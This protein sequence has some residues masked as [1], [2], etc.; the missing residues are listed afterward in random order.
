MSDTSKAIVLINIGTPDEP[1]IP[2]VYRYLTQFLNDKRVIDLPY[3]LRKFLVNAIIIPFRVKNSTE[4]YKQLW[5]ENGSPLLLHLKGLQ[6][7]LQDIVGKDYDIFTAMRYGNP[8]MKQTF[9]QIKARNYDEVVILPLFP[10]YA[11]ST[12]GSI[13]EKF[14]ALTKDWQ[15]IPNFKFISQYHNHPAFIKAL[16]AQIKQHDLSAYDH[17][18]FSYHGLPNRHLDN[19]HSSVTSI[20]CSCET[21]KPEHG[22]F[23]YK[24]NCYETTRLLTKALDLNKDQYSVAFQSR[25]S[26]NWMTPFTDKTIIEKAKNGSRNILIVAPSFV[27]DCLETTIELGYEYK[28]LFEAHGGKQLTLVEGLNAQTAWAE[29]VVEIVKS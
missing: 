22:N 24:A 17:I 5:T 21:Q 6:E 25:L 16:T 12:T 1:K 29:A 8:S 3:V 19:I 11:S 28:E 9:E 13:Y 23:C 26:K 27:A 15:S 10:Q 14:T 2:A 7:Q 20:S 18:I 4:L